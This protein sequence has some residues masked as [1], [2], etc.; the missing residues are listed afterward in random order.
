MNHHNM[1]TSLKT[2]MLRS[3]FCDDLV[4]LNNISDFAEWYFYSGMLFGSREKWWGKG[5]ERSRPHE[6]LDICYYKD[7]EQTV[8]TLEG[9]VKIPAM[10][11]GVV[12]EISDD[13]FLG[14]SIFI[15][16]DEYD[17]NSNILH[18][19]FAH[20]LPV[21]G[22]AVNQ[23]IRRND[24]IARIADTRGMNL[25]VPG[26]LHVSMI[27]LPE[28]Y[29]KDQLKWQILAVSRRARLVDPV[30]YLDRAFQV[31]NYSSE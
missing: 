17:S 5:G 4:E 9:M 23:K 19:V 8:R 28:D 18:S 6:G 16:H 13:D 7:S 3:S 12:Y 29:P 30:D 21:T 2:Q 26:H 1:D 10:F 11:D 25:A 14:K 20:T 22:L 15:R 27:F 24:V 31:E